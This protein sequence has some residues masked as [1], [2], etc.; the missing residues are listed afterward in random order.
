[1]NANIWIFAPD[2]MVLPAHEYKLTPA[3]QQVDVLEGIIPIPRII[4]KRSDGYAITDTITELILNRDVM[5]FLICPAGFAR[6]P[7]RYS[8]LFYI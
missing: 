4:T 1:M 6:G 3:V 8:R 2:V 7:D 5:F